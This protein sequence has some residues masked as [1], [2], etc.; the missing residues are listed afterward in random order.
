MR[1]LTSDLTCKPLVFVG[2]KRPHM[3]PIIAIVG[4]PNVGKSRFFNRLVGGSR[5]IVADTPG[6]TRDRHYAPADWLGQEFIA[7]DTGGLEFDPAADLSFEISKQSLKAIDEA[8]VI[9]CLFDGQ[10]EPSAADEEVVSRLRRVGVP[11]IYAV[12]KIDE[13]EHESLINCYHELGASPIFAVSAE[14]GRGIDDLLDEAAKHFKKE[15][16]EEDDSRGLRVAVIGRPNVGKSTLINRLSGEDRVVAHD[17]PGTTRDAIDVKIEFEGKDYVFVDTAGVKRRWGVSE[18]LERAT[19][20]RSLRTIDRA[21]V[22]LQLIDA[23]DG[24]TK[25][26][27]SLTGFIAEQG[28]GLILLVNK[29]DLAEAEWDEYEKRLRKGMGEL[30]D[31]QIMPISAEKGFNCLKIFGAVSKL[32][33]ALGKKVSTS[34][35]NRIIQDALDS[36]HLP[37][38]HGKQV[39][40]NY[41]T[42]TGTHPP[43]FALFANYPAAVPYT[44]RRYLVK[45]LQEAL[46]LVGV[47]VRIVCRRKRARSNE[48]GTPKSNV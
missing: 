16:E 31:I 11:V 44:Y 38:H 5:A 41:A 35:L 18:R 20:M 26:D 1:R 22:V 32:D 43:T 3:K 6:V 21:Q 2:I 47:P 29:W 17:M 30:H 4:R 34:E 15:P 10:N 40:I 19:A 25:Q 42:Q 36:H 23:A 33:F 39:R 24:L 46:G 13:T 14:H 8:D 27:L 48:Y 9:I 37:V 12:N 7:V 28:K 45:K